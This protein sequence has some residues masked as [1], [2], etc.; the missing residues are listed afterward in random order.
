MIDVTKLQLVLQL[1]NAGGVV[2]VLVF[3]VWAFYRGEVISHAVF[4]RILQQY[5]HQFGE[6][7]E[8]ILE[9]IDTALDK[10]L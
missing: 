1:I 2:G 8:R 6:L 3:F 4:E 10:R 7:S 5:E 9:R